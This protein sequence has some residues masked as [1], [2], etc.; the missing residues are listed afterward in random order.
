ML[1]PSIDFGLDSNDPIRIGLNLCL[2]RVNDR[3]RLK[4]S[5][6]NTDCVLANTAR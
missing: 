4:T 1:H 3:A 2:E 6:D 5:I